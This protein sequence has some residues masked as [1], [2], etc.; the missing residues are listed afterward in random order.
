MP[1][2]TSRLKSLSD[3]SDA[4]STRVP[5]LR[6]ARW[7]LPVLSNH[8]QIT[9]PALMEPTVMRGPPDL[10]R[11]RSPGFHW[12]SSDTACPFL[13]HPSSYRGDPQLADGLSQENADPANI[14]S[15]IVLRS[16]A[17]T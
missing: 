8:S 12:I 13:R 5:G 6:N 2:S 15:L 14:T 16:A 7:G 10:T 1:R 9:L 4:S 3:A 11:T 17:G